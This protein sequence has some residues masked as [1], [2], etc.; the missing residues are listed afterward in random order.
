MTTRNEATPPGVAHEVIAPKTGIYDGD[1][2]IVRWLP[3]EG[4]VVRA[5]DPIFEMETEKVTTEIEAE[6]DG[7]LHVLVPAGETIPIG[8]V[9]GLI[10][11]TQ[12][13]YDRLSRGPQ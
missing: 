5:G 6:E 3:P 10:A 7:I 1:V 8:S 2:T 9:V 12:T 4:A 13:E 11:R